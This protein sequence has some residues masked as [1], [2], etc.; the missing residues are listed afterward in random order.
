MVFCPEKKQG[1]VEEY[2]K[3]GDE[4][5][6]RDLLRRSE[7]LSRE[8]EIKETLDSKQYVC[9]GPLL[10][11]V[12]RE[13][14]LPRSRFAAITPS[15]LGKATK[16]NRLRRVF[17]ESFAKIKHKFAKNVDLVVFPGRD[18]V[19]IRLKDAE[20]ALKAGLSQSHIIE[21]V[22]DC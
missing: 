6:E 11:F 21:N 10:S 22:S 20:I 8:R 2:Y 13:N 17:V 16:R 7:R 5:G 12:A 18:L 3:R 4:K 15:G 9:K 1:V 14:F 19:K